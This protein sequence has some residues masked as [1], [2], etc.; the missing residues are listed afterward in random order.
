MHFTIN[1]CNIQGDEEKFKMNSSFLIFSDKS[2][3][4]CILHTKPT[5]WMH[6]LF[7]ET[8]AQWQHEKKKQP[9]NRNTMMEYYLIAP[10][11]SFLF[12][13]FFIHV[14]IANF[15]FACDLTVYSN[16]FT[17]FFDAIAIANCEANH[18]SLSYFLF[19]F[20]CSLFHFQMFDHTIS[21]Y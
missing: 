9:L 14:K 13:L 20:L 17:R 3:F 12:I 1:V 7:V 11:R 16:E 4:L 2:D 10:I 8:K 18:F 5:N 6:F 15:F 19:K 21:Q